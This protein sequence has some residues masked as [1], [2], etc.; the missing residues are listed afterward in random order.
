[1]ILVTGGT[2]H[3]GFRLVQRLLERGEEV[4]LFTREPSR[5]RIDLRR[6]MQIFRGNVENPEDIAEAVAGCQAVMSLTHIRFAPRIIAAMESQGVRRGIFM[7]STRRFTQ[8]PEQTARWV[9]DGESALESSRLDWTIIRPSMIYGGMRD[10]NMT[11]LVEVLRRFRIHPMVGGGRMLMQP[12][13]VWDV[14]QA[15]LAALDNPQTA[16]H[17]YTIAGPEPVAYREIVKAI[18]RLMRKRTLLL[19]IPI[20][21]AKAVARL[22]GAVSSKPRI[23]LDQIQ[24]LEEDKVFDITD[25]RRDLG[26][27]PIPFEEGIRRKLANKV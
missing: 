13:F 10:N 27:N 3:T 25:A 19:P 18:L 6:R 23:R 8:F 4:R 11:H 22:Y 2:G 7:S 17:A 24:R 20:S 14:V 26:F 12:V 15:L 5:M 16:R 9:I 1:M 21:C